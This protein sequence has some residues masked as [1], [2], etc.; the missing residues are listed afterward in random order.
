MWRDN[1]TGI[2]PFAVAFY[3]FRCSLH[4][5]AIN[6]L[7]NYNHE[8]V[9]GFGILYK[10]YFKDYKESVPKAMIEDFF[11]QS[12]K[13]DLD[14]N[15]IDLFKEALTHLMIGNNFK[16]INEEVFWTKLVGGDL[17]THLWFNVNNIILVFIVLFFIVETL[18]L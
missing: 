10:Q 6:Y 9:Q 11:K 12:N 3:M 15:S 7:C 4:D 18:R 2:F 13:I 17:D 1:A 16:S 8:S 14:N 5:F